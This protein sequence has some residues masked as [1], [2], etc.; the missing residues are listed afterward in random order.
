M[1]GLFWPGDERAGEVMSDVALLS[2]LVDVEAR[3]LAAL[4]S[5]G[6]APTSAADD[7]AGLLGVDDV[8]TVAAGAEAGGNPVIPLV[9]LMRSRLSGR[10]AEAAGWLHRGLTSQD[11]LDT[12]LVLC[13]RA[14]LD[15]VLA[16]VREQVR[17]MS[18]LAEAHGSTL[19]LGRTLTQYAVP[20]TF[21]LK[22]AG[23]LGGVLDAAEDLVRVRGSLPVQVGGAAGTAAAATALARLT[24]APDPAGTATALADDLA[25]RLGLAASPPWHT[26]RRTITRIGDALVAGT[27]AWGRIANDVLTLARPEIGELSE[28]GGSERGGSSTMPQKQNPLLSLLIRRAALT[29][30]M[31]GAQLHLAA[32]EAVDERPD[33]AWHTEWAV[34]RTLSRIAVVA[35]SQA[36][37]LLDGLVVHPDRMRARLD[38]VLPDVL[39]ERHAIRTAV[40]ADDSPH[41]D[42]PEHYLGASENF[43]SAVLDRAARFGKETA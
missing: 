2:A 11:V 32:A 24:G 38:S 23:W 22:V 41:D 21:A 40:G 35:A 20:V 13:S 36:A 1:S 18:A 5:S 19:M 4:V 14:A 3:W 33:G 17:R 16:D 25:Y 30:P 39:A 37:E 34:L 31:L 42:N 9:D 7:L 12:A 6:V 29:S 27:D 10:N 28:A 15:Q 8:D 26:S 43:V